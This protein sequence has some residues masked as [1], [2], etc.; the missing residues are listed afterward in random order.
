MRSMRI[1]LLAFVVIVVIA[2]IMGLTWASPTDTSMQ[3]SV[4]IEM[5]AEL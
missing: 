3:S 1:R 5:D 2:F 4:Y